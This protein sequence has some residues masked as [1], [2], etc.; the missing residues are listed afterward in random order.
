[1]YYAGC[2]G[3]HRCWYVFL[4]CL[5]FFSLRPAQAADLVIRVGLYNNR[6]KMYCDKSRRA[7]G[8]FPELLRHIAWK[9]KWKIR[10]MYGTWNQ[11][12]ARLTRGDIDLMPD[13]AHSPE[14]AKRYAFNQ[15]SVF[16]NW[17]IVYC[18]PDHNIN[19]VLDLEGKTIAVMRNSIHYTGKNGIRNLLF[20]FRVQNVRFTEVDNY[21]EVFRLLKL[22]EADVGIVNRIFGNLHEER[23][24][25]RKTQIVFNPVELRFA[26]PRGARKNGKLIKAIDSSLRKLKEDYRSAYYALISKHFLE[27]RYPIADPDADMARYRVLLSNEEQAWIKRHPVIRYSIDP[28]FIPFEFKAGDGTWK[29][30]VLDYVRLLRCRFGLNLQP[31]RG[32]T[33]VQSVERV[34]AG[35][36]DVLPAVAVSRE[37]SKFLTFS[38]PYISFYRVIITRDDAGPVFELADIADRKIAVQRASSHHGYLEEETR[39]RPV[40]YDSFQECLQ[41]VMKGSVYACIGNVTVAA[42]WIRK[43][44]LSQ[45]RIAAP[46]SSAINTLH[47]GVRKDWPRLVTIINK[48][49]Q[50]VSRKEREQIR[51]RWIE[52]EVGPLPHWGRYIRVVLIVLL[53]LLVTTAVV[54][55]WNRFMAREIAK[56]KRTEAELRISEKEK[57]NIIEQLDQLNQQKNEYLGIVSHDLR[58]PICAINMLSSYLLQIKKNNLDQDLL[59]FI[60][61]ITQLSEYMRVLIEDL[62]DFSKIEAGKIGL[63]KDRIDYRS[64][65]LRNTRINA[66]LA[67]EKEIAI[68]NVLPETL[69][70]IECDEKK[71]EQV[72]N[73]LVGNA[74]K[75]SF[76]KSTVTIEVRVAREEGGLLTIIKDSGPGIPGDEIQQVF[77]PFQRS[78]VK[79]MS[80]ER[81][82]GLGLAIAKRIIEAH[83]GRIGVHSTVGEGSEFYYT[84]PLDG[85]PGQ[86]SLPGA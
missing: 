9:K 41:A 22:G 38:K 75:Y 65:I 51:K 46:A 8:F 62:L 64:L 28:E 7:L 84:L 40:P 78:S 14:R 82:T 34:R 50:S 77:E 83:G 49:L 66:T 12:L 18:R 44:G 36:L 6:P 54:V 20:H 13:V 5:F 26:L 72:L 31:V 57:S 32:L 11:C 15:T 68:T 45:L 74:I 60:T 86:P 76:P 27:P 79:A 33:W 23:Y 3:R 19:N 21:K 48:G 70:G 67:E 56:R 30:M 1:M 42:Y 25:L 80:G 61:K 52:V 4:C 43:L 10:Y 63:K 69:P 29:G 81:S 16:N 58:N 24:Q 47:L 71:I 35:Q 59:E 55:I 53:V 39:I 2:T 37:R 17:G 85:E 73:N